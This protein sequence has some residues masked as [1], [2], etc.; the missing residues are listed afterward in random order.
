MMRLMRG[1]ESRREIWQ[2]R[3]YVEAT[4]R[5]D[6][7]KFVAPEAKARDSY[8]IDRNQLRL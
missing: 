5:E 4:R 3:V 7:D 8:A 2:G 6:G 1:G